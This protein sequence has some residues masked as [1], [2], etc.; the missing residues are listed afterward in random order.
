[1]PENIQIHVNNPCTESWDNMLPVQ[2]GRHCSSCQ[3]TV[4]DFSLMTDQEVLDWFAGPRE[5]VCGRFYPSQL[6][7]ELAAP[8]KARRRRSWLWHYFVAGLL[9]SSE[10][11]AQERTAIPAIGQH[12]DSLREDVLLVGEFAVGGPAYPSKPELPDTLRGRLISAA[13]GQSVCYASIMT[14]RHHGFAA[15]PDGYFAIPS[16]ALKSSHLTISAVGYKTAEINVNKMWMDNREKI[17]PLKLE[18]AVLGEFVVVRKIPVVQKIEAILKDTLTAAGLTKRVLT[19]YPNPVARGASVTLSL[20]LDEPDTYIAQLFSSA[21]AL[22]QT[23]TVKGYQKSQ[24]IPMN[25]PSSLVA[26]AYFIRVS[27]PTGT[28]VHTQEVIVY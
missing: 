22:L 13:D 5:S 28:V 18:E 20:R 21:G 8:P 25:I 19:V 14:D 4:I 1:M 23:I 7:H 26:G 2:Q 16:K 9:F 6:S 3:K 24:Q 15:D 11:S 10:V 12:D 17:I 27:R